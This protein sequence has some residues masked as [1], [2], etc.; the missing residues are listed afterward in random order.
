MA[1]PSPF[2]D[3]RFDTTF[4]VHVVHFWPDPG[5]EFAEIRRVLR[6]GGRL[7]VGFRPR[8]EKAVAGLPCSVYALRSVEEITTL[9]LGAGFGEVRGELDRVGAVA[10]GRVLARA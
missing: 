7:L 1:G 6:P 8:D 10:I 9:L 2:E 4:A 3:H 5:F